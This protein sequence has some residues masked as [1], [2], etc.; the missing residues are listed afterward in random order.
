MGA[1]GEALVVG[2]PGRKLGAG[3]HLALS[4]LQWPSVGPQSCGQIEISLP[5][6]GLGGRR[7]GDKIQY[8]RQL[9][10]SELCAPDRD[11]GIGGV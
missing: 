3:A 7:L 8:D 1:G 4:R 2:A 10:P 5:T 6:E 9:R 11:V